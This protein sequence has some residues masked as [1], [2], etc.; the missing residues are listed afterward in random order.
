MNFFY[1]KNMYSVRKIMFLV[2]L[3][4]VPAI[5]LKCYFFGFRT[6]IQIFLSVI[7]SLS[8]EFVL[9]KIRKKRVKDYL[10]DNSII[11]T[12]VLF[13]MSLP[14]LFPYWM[15]II[16]IFFSVVIAK[17]LYGG[18]GHNI[19]NPAMLG[20]TVLLIS[21]P[22]N[23]NNWNYSNTDLFSLKNIQQSFNNIVFGKK[24]YLINQIYLES[25]CN[26]FTEATTLSHFKTEHYKKNTDVPEKISLASFHIEKSWLYINISC[27]LS[28]FFLIFKKIICWRIPVTLLTSLGFLSFISSYY[29]KELFLSPFFH[30]FSGGTML[31]A[32]FIATDPVTT[33]CT[34]L[35]KIIFGCIIGILTWIIR[36][37]SDYPDG[38]AFSILF[39]NMLVPIID[40]YV[41]KSGYGHEN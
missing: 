29:S 22:I 16:G 21:F 2:I 12:A 36:N 4:C 17:H 37:Y 14:P 9:L 19:F 8:I 5:L 11:L 32:F 41:N 26:F 34:N 15:M 10:Q 40:Y 31:G 33:S 23:M 35:G 30:I 13:S 28:G 18:I 25:D 1:I 24:T 6:L 27:L 38:I 3:A 7:L 20:Y 39:A